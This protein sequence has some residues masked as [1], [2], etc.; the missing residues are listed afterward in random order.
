MAMTRYIYSFN[1]E[2]TDL[3]QLDNPAWW[4][5]N[6]PQQ[7]FAE[8]KLNVKRYRRGILPFAALG[9][10]AQVAI[11]DEYLNVGEIFF[12]IGELPD[13]PS[14]WTLEKKLTCAQM[15]CH[16]KV[17]STTMT[18]TISP[19]NASH[20]KDMF[21]LI[22]KVQPGYYE[23]DT[24][25]LGTYV[26]IWDRDKLVAIAGERMRLHQLT[27]I[28]AICTDPEYT[29]RQYAQQSMAH[30]CKTNLSKGITPFLHVLTTN[31]R[32]IRLYEFMGFKTRRIISFWKLVKNS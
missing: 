28:S 23:P 2:K 14:N 16:Q 10:Y 32:A 12:L 31:E 4:A 6:G 26:G 9:P 15:V 19:L 7:S 22:Q 1:I 13:L 8:G 25:Q 17:F 24:H 30:L 5:L 18:A 29:G 21:D 27:E 11:L 20:K 3:T